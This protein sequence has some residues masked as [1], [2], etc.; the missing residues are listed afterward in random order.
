MS[1]KL[2]IREIFEKGKRESGKD[3]KNGI[4]VYLWSYFEDK[5]HFDISD[6]T[7]VR[8]NDAYLRDNRE[9]NIEPFV[10]DKFSQ[11]LEFKDFKDFCKT[12]TFTKVN[13]DSSRTS[14]NVRIDEDDDSERKHPNITVNIT[15]NPILKLQEFFAKQSGFGVIGLL[16]F[17]GFLTNN[18]FKKE[19]IPV[20]KL[21]DINDSVS[22]K[23]LPEKENTTSPEIKII[24]IEKVIREDRK[25][26][27]EK[28]RKNYM[29]WNGECF[30]ETDEVS[31]G[32]QYEVI[33]M[34]EDKLKYFRKITTPDTIT[35]KSLNKIWYSKHHNVVQFFTSDG[36]NPE[37][38]KA[39][40]E[41]SQHMFDKYIKAK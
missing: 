4:A 30:T 39:L 3:S 13:K 6:K 19:E 11:Y 36:K 24:P 1:K 18:Y 7:L 16:V 23:L 12:E 35:E 38:G 17:A 5:M 40:Q 41:L 31:L 29:Y 32:S 8:Y 14:V 33:P 21:A 37:N 9:V 26:V 27:E 20:A 25:V 10:L 28:Q 22:A 2:L 34:N 15:T